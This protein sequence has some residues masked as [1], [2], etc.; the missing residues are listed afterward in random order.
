[1]L[2]GA[3]NRRSVMLKKKKKSL[4]IAITDYS[5]SEWLTIPRML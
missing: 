5:L 4:K 3:M 1:M 2:M